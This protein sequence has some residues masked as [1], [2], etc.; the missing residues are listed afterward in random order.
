MAHL[1]SKQAEFQSQLPLK[2]GPE[3]GKE[4]DMLTLT[5]CDNFSYTDPVDGSVANGQGLRFV[6]DDGSR[7]IFRLSGTG[8]RGATVRLYLEQYEADVEKHAMAAGD[9][10][11]RLRAIALEMSKLKEFTGRSEPT[12]IT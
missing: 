5:M 10:L 2:Q 4:A 6:Y 11:S 1:E 12:V 9:A 3:K 8:S 7:I